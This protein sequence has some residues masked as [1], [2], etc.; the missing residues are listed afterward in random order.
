MPFRA[1]LATL[2]AKL[3]RGVVR[4]SGRGQGSSLPGLV[5]LRVDPRYLEHAAPQLGAVVLVAGTNGKT[6]TARLIA[7]ALRAAGRT[8][9]ANPEGANLASGAAAALAAAA[10]VGGRVQADVAVLEADEDAL[11]RLARAL[12]PHVLVMTNLF[13][14]QLDRYGEV[15][16]IA[17]R[18]RGVVAE[19]PPTARLVIN[20]ND[21]RLAQ[22]ARGRRSTITFGVG[23]TQ[24]VGT[25]NRTAA[26]AVRCPSCGDVLHGERFIAHLG[27][28]TC[29]SC[30]YATPQPDVALTAYQPKGFERSLVTLLLPSGALEVPS[31]LVGRYNAFNIA[32]AAAAAQALDIPRTAFLAGVAAAGR[33][34]GRGERLSVAGR[35][36]YL[37]LAKN[38]TGYNE[39]LRG[40]LDVDAAPHLLLALNDNWADGQD[41][42]W[43][44][45]VDFEDV[46]PRA[47]SLSVTGQRAGDLAL[48]LDTAGARR[49]VA[50]TPD[51]ERAFDQA[52]QPGAGARAAP[53]HVVASYTALL[54]LRQ[55]LARR[56]LV[57]TSHA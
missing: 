48:R 52:T 54:L 32:A 18:W 23:N 3:T 35:H 31:A 42:S 5:A 44:W 24:V 20:A 47:T 4:L 40:I 9:V 29:S 21:P 51:L 56:G 15:D 39:V 30:D 34:F 8:V 33:A 49:E 2:A 37:H 57:T 25:P 55:R 41:V 10:R 43:I 16:S 19:L 36:V 27:V 14:D 45:D 6:T 13:R 28:L 1:R 38:P 53:L 46:A 12:P 26:D 7:A 11:P 17:R 50:V 22:L